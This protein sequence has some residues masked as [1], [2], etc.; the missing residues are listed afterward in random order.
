M[1]HS[2]SVTPAA[3]ADWAATFRGLGGTAFQ[4]NLWVPD[5][6]PARDHAAEQLVRRFLDGWGPAVPPE[7]GDAPLQDF[8]AQCQAVLDAG[9]N[10]TSSVMGLYP[11]DMVAEMKQRGIAWFACATTLA[12]A[13]AAESAG[14]DAIIAQGME[15][16]GHR[17]CFDPASAE[18]GLVGLMALVPAVVDAVRVPV[19]AAGGIADGRGVAAA[20][21][22]G[23][24]AVAVG[25]GYLRAPEAGI[26]RAW[27]D[28]LA[29]TPPEG[30]IL[31]RAFS[32]RPG[33]GL[34]NA[35][36]RA[37][38]G[39]PVAPY[40]VQRGLT[41]GMRGAAVATDDLARMQAWAGQSASLA[42]AEPAG[43]LTRRLWREAL[44]LLG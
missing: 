20:L 1:L 35:Y 41:A 19:V 16:G 39:Q 37:A 32:G 31:T 23:A 17:G 4:L 36:A 44:A 11:P 29:T 43:E 15:A 3:I 26:A 6:A 38:A 7:A 34:A 28:T 21:M 30:T 5:P 22:L 2:R 9:P 12:E 27:A 24:S 40:P 8:A 25:T 13:V 33:R 14:A 10:A 42:K 18:A